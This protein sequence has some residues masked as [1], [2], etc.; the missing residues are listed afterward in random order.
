MLLA[1]NLL[2]PLYDAGRAHSPSDT[3]RHQAVLLLAASQLV[4]NRGGQLGA[5]TP[6]RMPQRDGAAV[7]VQPT[8]GDAELTYNIAD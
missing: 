3:H 1:L 8:L 2:D 4:E 7:D 5:R 6:Q